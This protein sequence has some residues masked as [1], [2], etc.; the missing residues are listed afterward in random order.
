M[1]TATKLNNDFLSESDVREMNKAIE[2][3]LSNARQE[4]LNGNFGMVSMYLKDASVL[5]RIVDLINQGKFKEAA[6]AAQR[7]DTAA[8]ENVPACVWNK[9]ETHM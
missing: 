5:A 4:H 2:Q 3:E 8:R 7:Q 9:L 1:A 6:E